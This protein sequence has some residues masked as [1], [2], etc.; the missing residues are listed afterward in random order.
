MHRMP[1]A[2]VAVDPADGFDGAEGKIEAFTAMAD[3]LGS[4]LP[5]VALLAEL[6]LYAFCLQ[7]RPEW[8]VESI[9]RGRRNGKS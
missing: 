2:F 6:Y 3:P 5:T 8:C 1:D 4:P 7:T 9:M